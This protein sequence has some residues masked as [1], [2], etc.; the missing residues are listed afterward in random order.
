MKG[1]TMKQASRRKFHY[2]YRI[3]R[4]D[5]SG[6]YYIGMH[7]TDNLD[8][9]YFGSGQLLWKS[10]KK[11]GKEKHTKEIL[12]QLPSREA[13][14]LREAQLVN[15]ECLR[16]ALCM[17]LQ[18]GGNGG[19]FQKGR[20]LSR[21]QCCAI[22]T[23]R[24]GVATVLQHSDKTKEI[25]AEHAKKR[26]INGTMK[27]WATTISTERRKEMVT[28]ANKIRRIP[29][30]QYNLDGSFVSTWPGHVEICAAYEFNPVHLTNSL[31]NPLLPCGNFLWRRS[32]NIDLLQISQEQLDEN[33]QHRRRGNSKKIL[34]LNEMNEIVKTWPSVSSVERE[35]GCR[36]II[37]K[38]IK[39]GCPAYGSYWKKA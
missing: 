2:I 33:K 37:D 24:K 34:Q 35:F 26:L 6:K 32:K 25:M 38:A 22:S 5:G 19:N 28:K 10:I 16:D 12:E 21:E 14:K 13:L 15:H 7:S 1:N 29:I 18:L 27:T 4:T 17:N 23:R 8:D 11:H 30:Q 20:T 36:F 3:T 9:G 39:T 31:K